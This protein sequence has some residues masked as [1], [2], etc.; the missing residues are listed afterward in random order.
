M[1]EVAVDKFCRCVR[2]TGSEIDT[3]DQSDE[4]KNLFDKSVD[5]AFDPQYQNDRCDGDIEVVEIHH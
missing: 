2:E 3:G 1:Q 5:E 4:S